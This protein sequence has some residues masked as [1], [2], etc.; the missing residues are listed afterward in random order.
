MNPSP[1]EFN[2]DFEHDLAEV[3]EGSTAASYIRLASWYRRRAAETLIRAS[4]AESELRRVQALNLVLA[5]RLAICSALL[6]RAA[7]RGASH[8]T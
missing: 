8:A 3:W 5:E 7:E 6:T 1:D 2:R 4:S